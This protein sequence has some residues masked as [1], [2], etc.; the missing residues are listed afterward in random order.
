MRSLKR[1]AIVITS[2][3]ILFLFSGCALFTEGKTKLNEYCPT[4]TITLT[5]VSWEKTELKKVFVLTYDDAAQKQAEAYFTKTENGYIEEKTDDFS[6]I[7]VSDKPIIS[8]ADHFL[9]KTIQ[10]TRT[11]AKV[12]FDE[13]TQRI[14]IIEYQYTKK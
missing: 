5:G 9:V 13:S 6:T 14:I 12:I 4:L 8:K 2:F 1:T 11:T 10:K 3:L 7:K